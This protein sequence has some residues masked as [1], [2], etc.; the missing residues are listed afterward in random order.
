[1]HLHLLSHT[2]IFV[3]RTECSTH[4]SPHVK[5]NAQSE[6]HK[7]DCDSCFELA[8]EDFYQTRL[9]NVSVEEQQEYHNDGEQNADI[10]YAAKQ[11]VFLSPEQ[12]NP[13]LGLDGGLARHRHTVPASV[14]D[15]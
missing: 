6:V 11:I 8:D 13:S 3:Y 12:N 14:T 2:T 5:T 4:H 9:E 1:M 10:L 7:C 15:K